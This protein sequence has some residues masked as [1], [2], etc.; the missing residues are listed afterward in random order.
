MNIKTNQFNR[1]YFIFYYY[2]LIYKMNLKGV[3]N[4]KRNSYAIGIFP[5]M[6][7]E[8]LLKPLF[9]IKFATSKRRERERERERERAR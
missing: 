7:E 2:L 6:Y 3:A 4:E 5:R 1:N 9:G 8:V